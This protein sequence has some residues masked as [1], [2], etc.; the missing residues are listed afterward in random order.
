MDNGTHIV[1]L[2]RTRA[3]T[4]VAHTTAI[5]PSSELAGAAEQ[6]AFAKSKSAAAGPTERLGA[7]IEPATNGLSESGPNR[8]HISN[9]ALA[10]HAKFQEQLRAVLKWGNDRTTSYEMATLATL[11][12][13]L[14]KETIDSSPFWSGENGNTNALGLEHHEA[15]CQAIRVSAHQIEHPSCQG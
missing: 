14:A 13:V 6:A 1:V 15:A 10:A 7:G 8:D 12:P 11:D 4:T 3:V 9:Q 2:R 5:A